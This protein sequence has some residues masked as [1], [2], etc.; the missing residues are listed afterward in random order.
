MGDRKCMQC[1]REKSQRI[2]TARDANVAFKLSL[3]EHVSST[4]LGTLVPMAMM[5]MMRCWDR[6][7]RPLLFSHIL[8]PALSGTPAE[9][10]QFYCFSLHL[11]ST[12][13]LTSQR[14]A[15]IY[16]PHDNFTLLECSLSSC[17]DQYLINRE[18]C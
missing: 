14:F 7:V 11:K 13:N 10:I 8:Q 2:A 9:L 17:V 1:T 5:M 18:P 4:A 12:S 3:N 6:A 15:P 16:H